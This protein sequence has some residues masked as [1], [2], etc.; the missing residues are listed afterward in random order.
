M[1]LVGR[2]GGLVRMRGGLVVRRTG[3]AGCAVG[4]LVVLQVV[5]WSCGWCGGL[6]GDVG[7]LRV[8]WG[9]MARGH[10]AT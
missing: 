3:Q 6:A 1:G 9:S 8:V 2:R 10:R 7:V 4:V 5:W